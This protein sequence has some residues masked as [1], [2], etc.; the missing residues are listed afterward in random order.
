MPFYKDLISFTHYQNSGAAGSSLQGWARYLGILA[1]MIVAVILYYRKKGSIQG[2]FKECGAA[3][4]VGGAIGNGIERLLFGKVTDF[5]VFRSGN[6]VM[7]LAD[8]LLIWVW[9][10]LCWICFSLTGIRCYQKRKNSKLRRYIKLYIVDLKY[11]LWY[12]SS[13]RF[14]IEMTLNWRMVT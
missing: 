8:L 4:F 1:V 5:I 14:L 10:F 11:Y 6:G 3:F 2:F 9:C 7:N 13:R 12:P